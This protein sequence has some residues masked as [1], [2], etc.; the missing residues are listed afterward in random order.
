MQ[1]NCIVNE[2]EISLSKISEMK[3]VDV[4]VDNLNV[5]FLF[6]ITY[7]ML[8]NTRTVTNPINWFS[9]YCTE[10]L[11]KTSPERIDFIPTPITIAIKNL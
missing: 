8:L 7:F 6:F 5:I 1:G 10:P 4:D 9:T 3:F 11:I 2:S